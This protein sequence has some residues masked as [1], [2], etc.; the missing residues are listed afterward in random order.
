MLIWNISCQLLFTRL[1][2]SSFFYFL[3]ITCRLLGSHRHQLDWHYCTKE[4]IIKT[5]GFSIYSISFLYYGFR[6]RFA[7]DVYLLSTPFLLQFCFFLDFSHL[8]L[9]FVA[10]DLF[11]LA[12]LFGFYDFLV[13]NNMRVLYLIFFSTYKI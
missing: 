13:F 10:F 12:I 7:S 1:S 2:S 6:F 4:S 9:Y 8:V 3:N 5:V 11:N